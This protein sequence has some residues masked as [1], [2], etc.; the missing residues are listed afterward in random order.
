MDKAVLSLKPA[1]KPQG[2]TPQPRR[3]AI[4][5]VG[6]CRN[7]EPRCG[8]GKAALGARLSH[9]ACVARREDGMLKGGYGGWF[10]WLTRSKAPSFSCLATLDSWR[11]A[12]Q[13]AKPHT[14]RHQACFRV[15]C[16]FLRR[17][18]GAS[19]L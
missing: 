16:C 6:T 17:R 18:Q 19:F 4:E 15:S 10:S 14:Q 11:L 13:G 1:Q 9:A 7:D 5:T 3:K 12:P 2:L 8:K